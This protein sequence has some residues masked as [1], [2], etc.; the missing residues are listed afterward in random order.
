MTSLPG[1]RA[2]IFQY[3]SQNLTACQ[4]RIGTFTGK[5]KQARASRTDVYDITQIRVLQ[6]ALPGF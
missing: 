5:L 1:T 4:Q 6:H 2:V 3:C